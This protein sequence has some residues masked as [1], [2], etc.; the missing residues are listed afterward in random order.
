MACQRAS[1]PAGAGQLGADR[2]FSA[3]YLF[4]LMAMNGSAG[5]SAITVYA[6]L[7]AR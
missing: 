1:L 2:L 7:Q 5:L 6:S 3:R 4:V